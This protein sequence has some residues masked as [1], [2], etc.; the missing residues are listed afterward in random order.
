MQ[1]PPPHYALFE[2]LDDIKTLEMWQC[3]KDLHPDCE[4]EEID[5]A[6][7]NSVDTFSP[8]FETWISQVPSKQTT[9]FRI[10]LI[11]HSEFLTYSCQQM[12]RRSLE[13]RSFKCRV[14]FHVEDPSPIQPAIFSRCIIK[15]ISTITHTPKIR[16]L[17][18]TNPSLVTK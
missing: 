2:P 3:Y 4:F 18:K 9:R 8:W 13:L 15:R 16:R 6:Q 14:W 12:L 11:L 10:L 17:S 7:V 5:G 1:Y